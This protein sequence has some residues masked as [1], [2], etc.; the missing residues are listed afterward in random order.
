MAKIFVRCI[1]R[2][3]TRCDQWKRHF[4]RRPSNRWW[5]AQSVKEKR[6]MRKLFSVLALLVPAALAI[7]GLGSS[8]MLP[9]DDEAIQ[10]TS[11]PVNDPVN[12]LQKRIDKG[13]VKL[14]Y[15]GQL[16]Y[17]R[18]V[19]EALNVSTTSQVLVFS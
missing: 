7:A 18:S 5:A 14:T 3:M 10:Y 8:D 19:L 6:A 4:G 11:G 12:A 1:A 15:E 13:D 17:L 9:L 16:G 2:W